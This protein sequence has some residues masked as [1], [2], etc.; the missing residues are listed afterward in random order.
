MFPCQLL[1]VFPYVDEILELMGNYLIDLTIKL[2]IEI[3][4]KKGAFN[5]PQWKDFSSFC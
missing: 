4:K 5:T 3:K 1:H 2:F